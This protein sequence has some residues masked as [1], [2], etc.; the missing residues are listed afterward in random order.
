VGKTKKNTLKKLEVNNDPKFKRIH[1]KSLMLNSYEIQAF[2]KYCKKY[3]IGNR[4][5]FMREAILS[6]IMKKFSDDYP[7]LW[8]QPGVAYQ[9]RL[10]L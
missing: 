4:S 3:K 8:E 7:S 1:R 9:L 5:K 10:A 2:E 6:T